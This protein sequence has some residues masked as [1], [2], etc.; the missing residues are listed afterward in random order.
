MT[1]GKKCDRCT[2]GIMSDPGSHSYDCTGP[3]R[4]WQAEAQQEEAL[5]RIDRWLGE[6]DFRS[7][8]LAIALEDLNDAV[9]YARGAGA[10]WEAIGGTLHTTRQAAQQRFG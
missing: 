7:R 3:D 4:L 6:V 10:T 5:A 8:E 2:T 1:K 9:Q